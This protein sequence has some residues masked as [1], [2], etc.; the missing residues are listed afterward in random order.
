[1]D[2]ITLDLSSTLIGITY[3]TIVDDRVVTL[4]TEALAPRKPTGRDFGYA[5]VKEKKIGNGYNAFLYP[6]EHHISMAEASRRRAHVKAETH[7]QLLRNI[8]IDL[9]LRLERRPIDLLAIE[10]NASFNGILTTKLLAE[11]AG[12]LFFYSGLRNI[13]F[14]DVN[15]ATARSTVRNTIALSRAE[16]VEDDGNIAYD[17]KSEIRCRLKKIY[18]HLTDFKDI[19]LDESDSLAVFHH[20][21]E[22]RGWAVAT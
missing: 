2:V 15:V 18:G 16:R 10:R 19:T 14:E 17:T 3:A 11:I 12:G 9:G 6:D 1:M 4:E 20:L 5:T 21:K 13:P 7:K 22:Q 8:G